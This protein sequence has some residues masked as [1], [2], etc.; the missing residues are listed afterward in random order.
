MDAVHVMDVMDVMDVID[1]VHVRDTTMDTREDGTIPGQ[2][3]RGHS[4]FSSS[5]DP[6]KL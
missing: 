4:I 1:A 2:M 3:E 5:N 6:F